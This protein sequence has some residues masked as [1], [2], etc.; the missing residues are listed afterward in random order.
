MFMSITTLELKSIGC[1]IPF[2]IISPLSTATKEMWQL[3]STTTPGKDATYVM[4][5]IKTKTGIK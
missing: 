4:P 2:A 3:D 5:A 1:T